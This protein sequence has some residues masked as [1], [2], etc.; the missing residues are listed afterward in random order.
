M[1]L[2]LSDDYLV[3]FVEG[4]GTFYI[5][6]VPSKGT[7]GNKSGWQVI[8]F[9]KVSQNPGGKVVLDYLKKRLDCGYLKLNDNKSQKDKSLAFVVRDLQSLKDK[10]I[11][12]FEGKLVIKR[13]DFIKFKKVIELVDKKVH[14]RKEGVKQILDIAYSMNTRKRKVSKEEILRT[15]KD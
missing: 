15:Y 12:F 10:V 13:K 14:L 5:G 3:G 9:F 7:S 2:K 11:P 1:A 4:E 6:I 8:Y